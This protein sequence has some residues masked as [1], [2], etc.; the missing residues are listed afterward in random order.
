MITTLFFDLDGTLLPMDLSGF[1]HSYIS[2]ISRYMTQYG[3]D[4]KTFGKSLMTGVA[5]MGASS[6]KTNEELFWDYFSSLYGDQVKQYLPTLEHFYANEFNACQ[7]SCPANPKIPALIE[8]AKALGYRIVLATNPIFPKVAVEQRIR[9]AGLDWEDFEY[10]STY[11]NS[12]FIKPDPRYFQE[13]A[14]ELNIPCEEILMVGND[15]SEDVGAMKAGMSLYVLT[16][17]LIENDA[18]AVDEF[19]HGSVDDLS[20][21]L[22]TLNA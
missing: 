8:K 14:D 6:E 20:A 9:W 18:H 2:S 15:L 16:D 22:E 3:F 5:M 11:E 12:R 17:C 13:I 7:D 10:V 4:P 21:F 19:D 1:T